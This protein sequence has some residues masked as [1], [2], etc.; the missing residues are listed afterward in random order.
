LNNE[1]RTLKLAELSSVLVAI[2]LSNA[3]ALLKNIFEPASSIET[4]QESY[5]KLAMISDVAGREA[6]TM[7]T[8]SK[9]I[10]SNQLFE[11]VC[12]HHYYLFKLL[13]TLISDSLT[14]DEWKRLVK[15]LAEKCEKAGIR[16]AL[17]TQ[18]MWVI[19]ARL[20]I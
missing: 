18:C 3:E 10:E 16:Y 9:M 14:G 1:C 20:N 6:L 7:L 15:Q 2:F 12:F 5:D 4:A 19:S 11:K 17:Y 8:L 13:D